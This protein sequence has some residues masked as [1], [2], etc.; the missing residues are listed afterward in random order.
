MRWAARTRPRRP[1]DASES[2]LNLAYR[3]V[4][5]NRRA[6]LFV[7]QARRRGFGYARA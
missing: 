3:P 1:E 7:G 6:G 2:D 5:R 4:R